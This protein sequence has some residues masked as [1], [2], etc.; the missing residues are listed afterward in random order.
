MHTSK[1]LANSKQ[2]LKNMNI[3]T[4]Q[5]SFNIFKLFSLLVVLSFLGNGAKAQKIIDTWS[6][7]TGVDTTL[8]YHISGAD[9][10]IMAPGY[11]TSGRS[12]LIPIGFPFTYGGE[13]HTN[14]STN[15]NGTI[16][17]GDIQV[18]SSGHYNQPL[19]NSAYNNVNCPKI[20]PF[21]YRGLF[22]DSSYTRI[23]RLGNTGSRVLVIETRMTGYYW[24]VGKYCTFQVQVFETGGI[25]IVFGESED[26]AVTG[27]GHMQN[28]FAT[29]I[30]TEQDVIFVDYGTNEAMRWVSENSRTNSTWPSKGRWFMVAPDSNYCPFPAGVTLSEADS[31]GFT[32]HCSNI[33]EVDKRVLSPEDGVDTIWAKEQS[34]LRI[35]HPMNPSMAYQCVLEGVCDSGYASYRTQTLAFVTGCWEVSSLPWVSDY[36]DGWDCWDRTR[37][38]YVSKSWRKLSDAYGNGTAMRCGQTTTQ[39]YNEWLYSPVLQL[40]DTNGLTLQWDYGTTKV[41]DVA[42]TVEVRV[43]PCV[44][45]N[46]PDDSAWTTVLVLNRYYERS[47]TLY[48]NLDNYRGQR[49]KVAFVRTGSGGGYASVTNVALN[50]HYEPLAEIIAPTAVF[51]GDSVVLQGQMLAGVDSNVVW[52]WHST[53]KDTTWIRYG[54][55]NP[56][57]Q[58]ELHIVYDTAGFDTVTVTLTTAYGVDTVSAIV[59]VVGCDVPIPWVDDFTHRPL[60]WEID[61][62]TTLNY[63]SLYDENGTLKPYYSVLRSAGSRAYLLTPSITLPAEGMHNMKFWVESNDPMAVRLSTT[64]SLDTASYVDSLIYITET[65]NHMWWNVADLEQYAGQTVRIGIFAFSGYSFISSVKID[66]DTLIVLRDVAVPEMGYPDSTMVC[67]ATLQRGSL[68]SIVH[69]WHSSLMDTVFTESGVMNSEFK[70]RYTLGGIDTITYIVRNAYNSDTVTRLVDVKDCSPSVTLP[71]YEDFEH[72][73]V[74]WQKPEGS[75]WVAH[76][77]SY[78]TEPPTTLRYLYYNHK[79]DTMD[80]WIFSKPITLPNSNETPRLFWHAATSN[81]NFIHKYRVMITTSQNYTDT[82]SYTEIY[83]DSA[84]HVNFGNFDSLSVDLT[85]YA[86]QTIHL[87]FCRPANRTNSTAGLYI[88]NILIRSAKVPVLS[89]IQVASDIYTTDSGNHA[90]AVF[91]EG[92]MNGMVYVWHSTLLDSTWVITGNS[93][94]GLNY[95][96]DGIDTLSVAVTNQ[97]GTDSTYSVVSVHHCPNAMQVPFAESFNNV[98]D[99]GCWRKWSFYE[100]NESHGSWNPYSNYMVAYDSSSWLITPEIEIPTDAAGLNLKLKVAGSDNPPYTYLCAL[101]STTGCLDRS[102]FTDTIFYGVTSYYWNNISLP[103]S[104]YA[105]QNVNIAFVNSGWTMPYIRID[106]LQIDYDSIPRIISIGHEGISVEDT[107]IYTAV[108][109]NCVDDGLTYSW[110]STLN[111]TTWTLGPTDGQAGLSII[112]TTG[113]IDTVT[114]VFSNAYGADTATMVFRVVNCNAMALPYTEDFEGAVGSSVLDSGLPICWNSV[115]EGDD[116]NAPHVV[117]SGSFHLFSNIPNNALALSAGFNDGFDTLTDV[118][119]P[120][121]E[122]PLSYLKLVF[123]YRNETSAFGTLHVG[124]YDGNGEFV[125]V[126][127]MTNHNANSYRM[128][129]VEFVCTQIADAQMVLRWENDNYCRAVLIDNIDVLYND[130]AI[131]APEGL[132]VDSVGIDCVSLGWNQ[133]E[134][135][136][137]YQVTLFE[138]NNQNMYIGDTVVTDT[139]VTFSGLTEGTYYSANLRAIIG[140]D[141]SV[142]S[143]AVAFRTETPYVCMPVTDLTVMNISPTE[144]LI[145]W[146]PSDSGHT[147]AVYLGAILT[148]ETALTSHQLSSLMPGMNYSV[149]VREICSPG[150]TSDIVTLDFMTDCYGSEELP[151]FED[152]EYGNESLIDGMLPCWTFHA[153]TGNAFVDLLE[154]TEEHNVLYLTD[155]ALGVGNYLCTPPLAVGEQG[156]MVRFK[157]EVS[158]EGRLQAGVMIDKD[159]TTTFIPLVVVAHEEGEMVW[160]EFRTDSITACCNAGTYSVTFRWDGEVQGYVDSLMVDTVGQNSVGVIVLDETYLDCRVYPNPARTVVKVEIENLINGKA[161]IKIINNTGQICLEKEWWGG[162]TQIDV[163]TLGS[164]VYY[165][166]IA[167]E[168]GTCLKKLILLK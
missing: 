5:S 127:T 116:S 53:L 19:G 21:G 68:D 86:N 64:A 159:D 44:A 113:G 55:D 4:M 129:T 3:F 105:G 122:Y 89:R 130:L 88:D 42:P 161:T 90:E 119:L 8:W 162:R 111:D 80:S 144:V 30:L 54:F 115:W 93:M 15:I 51:A 99:L 25:R 36:V 78:F 50:Q 137:A 152:F 143:S 37:Y 100:G 13:T 81:A 79:N 6:F 18:Y 145:Q 72:G 27:S 56:D 63:C 166:H 52:S 60:C 23:A 32:L 85:Q 47:T 160:Y 26:D 82:S 70:L 66:Y 133:Y 48:A 28:G 131:H 106:D 154:D 10:V 107:V 102:H 87:A 151:F 75:N 136:T 95:Y 126:K 156:A 67:R 112:Y 24:E 135:A 138:G 33:G 153:G 22:D 46:N 31:N 155:T 110:H 149:G 49:V 139:V 7:D 124:Y 117:P 43:A 57:R 120:Y 167:A 118:I 128:D 103:L 62:W 123:G 59:D 69:I 9:S 104:Q 16:R 61:R 38:T 164:G 41:N 12:G 146:M 96:Y 29:E 40:P 101:V 91:Y 142:V 65:D 34:D 125:V 17:F 35:E 168:R 121:F 83:F 158:V 163:S 92:N 76:E 71:W 77:T 97:Y 74:C 94:T 150:D 84:R 114:L 134:G 98:S 165:V 109:N 140:T 157:S 148:T 20:E 58:N 11:R 108:V 1:T 141:T 39:T 45:D 147:F 73:I 132:N 2:T 14:F